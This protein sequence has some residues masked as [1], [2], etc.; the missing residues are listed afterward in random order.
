MAAIQRQI[1]VNAPAEKVFRYVSDIPR[2]VEWAGHKLQITPDAAG[3]AAVGSTF[4]CVGHQLGTHQGKVT[5]AE[6]TPNSKLVYESDD[7][8][9][10]FRHSFLLSEEGGATTVTKG[11]EPQP[12]SLPFKIM[13]PLLR[14][15]VIPRGL[16]G[17]LKRIK[18]NLEA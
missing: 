11:V 13:L 5:V 3:P 14:A 2:H 7:D 4:T 17:D 16:E 10:H 8:T 1:Q 15:T 12:R 9:G 18:A 6:L